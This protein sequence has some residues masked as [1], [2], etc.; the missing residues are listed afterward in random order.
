MGSRMATSQL[1]WQIITLLDEEGLGLLAAELLA[2]S[3]LDRLLESASDSSPDGGSTEEVEARKVVAWLQ[4]RLVE[5]ARALSEAERIAGELQ[6]RPKLPASEVNAV[7][8][9]AGIPIQLLEV[10]DPEENGGDVQLTEPSTGVETDEVEDNPASTGGGAPST[11]LAID[12]QTIEVLDAVLT[13]L[14]NRLK[15]SSDT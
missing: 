2:D 9:S 14:P 3:N 11:V 12:P 13:S 7:L 1:T 8:I 4:R 10:R 15:T 6:V 5:P